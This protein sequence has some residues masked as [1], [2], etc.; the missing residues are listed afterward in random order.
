LVL[1]SLYPPNEGLNRTRNHAEHIGR[2]CPK[3]YWPRGFAPVRPAVMAKTMRYDEH[4]IERLY[5]E[6][7]S[8]ARQLLA[9]LPVAEGREPTTKGLNG[10]VYEQTISY[11]L[12]QELKALGKLPSM[13]EQVPLYGRAKIDLLVGKV[14]IE[15][16]ALGSFGNDVRKYTGYRT[17]VEEKGW[18][19]CYLTRGE[20]YRPYRLATKAVFGEERAF[21]LD[22][23][24]DWERFVK[25]VLKRNEEK[26]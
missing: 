3:A 24:G 21:F 1:P 13:V 11:C 7:L 18:T 15:I 14:A 6:N 16:K 8:T 17:K 12:S 22:I 23:Q 20:T 4:E 25:E 19:Y 26:P 9:S 10:W 5:Q 2:C